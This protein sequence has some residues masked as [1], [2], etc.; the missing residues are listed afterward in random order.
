MHSRLILLLFPVLSLGLPLS[1][2]ATCGEGLE[3]LRQALSGEEQHLRTT[4]QT[5]RAAKAEFL[6]RDAALRAVMAHPPP[7]YDP[8][9]ARRLV[10]LRRTEVEPKRATLER[11]RVQQEE[12]RQQWE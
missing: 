6:S 3:E 4:E 2:H 7:G 11:L 1:T 9:L 5:V 10:E 12:A 8:A